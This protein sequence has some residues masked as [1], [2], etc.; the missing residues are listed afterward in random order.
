M[1]PSRFNS[2]ICGPGRS[3]GQISRG[4][5]IRDLGEMVTRGIHAP[6][7]DEDIGSGQ[8]GPDSIVEHEKEISFLYMLENPDALREQ[9]LQEVTEQWNDVIKA[10][11]ASMA[12]QAEARAKPTVGS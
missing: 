8:N 9:I 2:V 1:I 12:R 4:V 10:I 11:D 7:I 5:A 3:H 6:S